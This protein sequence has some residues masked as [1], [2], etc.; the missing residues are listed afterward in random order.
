MEYPDEKFIKVRKIALCLL[1]CFSFIAEGKT[2]ADDMEEEIG[3]MT[4][5]KGLMGKYPETSWLLESDAYATQE[6]KAVEKPNSWSANLPDKT[7]ALE[8]ERTLLSLACLHWIRDGSE[9][10]YGA[11]TSVQKGPA[12]LTKE[13]FN[14]LHKM[15]MRVVSPNPVAYFSALEAHLV[16]GD[17]E[18]RKKLE[19]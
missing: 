17:T 8:F 13:D 11:F 6:G 10:A 12:N 4:W 1:A 18:K 3:S 15:Y 19:I 14:A 16:L 5:V 2:S 9:R 7:Y